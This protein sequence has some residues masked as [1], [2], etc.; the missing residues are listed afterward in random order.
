MSLLSLIKKYCSAKSGAISIVFALSLTVIIAS[1]GIATD[2]AIA[3]N[4][5]NRLMGALDKSALAVG[6]SSGNEEE[7]RGVM[8]KFFNANYPADTFGTPYN[9]TLTITNG[10]IID[11]SASVSVETIFMAIFGKDTMDVSGESQVIRELAGIEAVL[12]LDVTGSMRG[13][14]IAALKTASTNFINTMFDEISDVEFL[15][16]GIVPYADTINVGRYGIG[17]NP[18]GTYYDTGFVDNPATDEYVTPASNIVYGTGTNDWHGCVVERTAEGEQMTDASAPNW[19]MYRYPYRCVR[20]SWYGCSEYSTPNYGCGSAEIV[21]LTNEQATL[22]NSIDNLPTSGN[23]YSNLGMVWAWR[24]ISPTFPFMEGVEYDDEKWTKTVILMTDGNNTV[25]SRYSTEGADGDPGVS[26]NT[27][28]QNAKLAQVCEDMKANDIRLYTV[29]FQSN[30]NETTKD[31]YRQCATSESMYYDA[32]SDDD[33]VVVFDKIA[34]QLSKLH[35]S[36]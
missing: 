34:D 12:V 17:L 1:A 2:L 36:K 8:E 31:I 24:L 11:V 29:T 22:Q 9:L 5:K 32:P 28:E 30:I 35:V 16:I 15:K 18:D 33:L 27:A 26:D 10:N 13:T 4:A 14:N 3:Y 19:H 7:L 23:T 21:P 25:D 6:S 20:S